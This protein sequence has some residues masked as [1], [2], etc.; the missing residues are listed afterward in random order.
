MLTSWG[1]HNKLP[2]F[3]ASKNSNLLS[4]SSKARRLKS[5]CQQ[6]CS[7]A[8]GSREEIL[9]SPSSS[10]GLWQPLATCA[11]PSSDCPFLIHSNPGPPHL[12]VTTSSK[13]LFQIW[14][15][16]EVPGGHEFLS[17]YYW[18]YSIIQPI[19]VNKMEKYKLNEKFFENDLRMYFCQ[20]F[21]SKTV[22]TFWTT[23]VYCFHLLFRCGKRM[24]VQQNVR[25]SLPKLELS[26][27]LAMSLGQDTHLNLRLGH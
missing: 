10:G 6:C 2:H 24:W 3:L 4:H 16:S 1:C 7:R 13:T 19:P 26:H 12:D 11:P 23:R 5:G 20:L 22:K 8:E 14:S 17:G 27:L 9:L 25:K 18:V 15:C 21:L